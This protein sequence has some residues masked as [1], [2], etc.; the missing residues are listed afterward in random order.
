MSRVSHSNLGLP[1]T[2]YVTQPLLRAV[3]LLNGY[4]PNEEPF[5]PEFVESFFCRTGR[6]V[7][8]ARNGEVKGFY[9]R[10]TDGY[11]T[12]GAGKRR[13]FEWA[14]LSNKTDFTKARRV[15]LMLKKPIN[16]MDVAICWWIYRYRDCFDSRVADKLSG[17][18][19]FEDSYYIDIVD[20]K[21][22][23]TT[24]FAFQLYNAR[25]NVTVRGT[26]NH[27]VNR[28]RKNRIG[29]EIVETK[30]LIQDR[31]SRATNV[32]SRSPGIESLVGNIEINGEEIEIEESGPEY[33]F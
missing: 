33:G 4:L 16:L 12:I 9:L 26:R 1:T 8:L 5:T 32:L 19:K 14:K 11:S 29:T 3:M 25:I 7:D 15:S 6:K 10:R 18:G 20:F 30:Q 31:L 2:G 22:P 28:K 24:E 23:V 17:N 13:K 27:K 21:T